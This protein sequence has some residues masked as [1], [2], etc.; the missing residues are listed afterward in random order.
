MKSLSSPHTLPYIWDKGMENTSTY[1]LL[2]WTYDFYT[3]ISDFILILCSFTYVNRNRYR[4]SI[5]SN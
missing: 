5:K 1:E 4:S 2:L 3:D